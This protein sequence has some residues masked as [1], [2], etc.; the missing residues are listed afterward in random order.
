[1]FSWSNF[2]SLFCCQTY[3][4]LCKYQMFPCIHTQSFPW[5]QASPKCLIIYVNLSTGNLHITQDLLIWEFITIGA[6][7]A[8]YGTS[9]LVIHFENEFSCSRIHH[10]ISH[11][12]FQLK[13]EN[14]WI[15]IFYDTF[16]NM[17]NCMA[18]NEDYL[19]IIWNEPDH[20]LT[21][22]PQTAVQ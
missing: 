22:I 2:V 5:C 16:P 21:K 6:A 9:L 11:P 20:L 18:D 1:M 13:Q 19:A 15:C 3:A 14:K 8:L 4:C 7:T 17:R 12:P 10:S